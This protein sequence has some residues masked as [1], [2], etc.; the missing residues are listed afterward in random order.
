LDNGTAPGDFDPAG[1]TSVQIAYTITGSSFAGDTWDDLRIATLDDATNTAAFINGTDNSGLGNVGSNTDETDSSPNTGLTQGNWEAMAVSG[2]T[3]IN[4]NYTTWNQDKGKD[5]GVQTMSA[6]VVTITYT[7]GSVIVYDQEHHRIRDDDAPALNANGGGDWAAAEDADW[8]GAVVEQAFRLRFSISVD[9]AVTEGFQLRA[10]KNGAGGYLLVGAESDPWDE[11]AGGSKW[12]VSAIPSAQYADL[13]ATTR[14]L[15]A[16]AGTFR[17]G[18]GNEDPTSG[19]VAFLAA[20]DYTEMEWTVIIRKLARDL[21]DA[22]N[23]HNDDNDFWDFRVYRDDGT[24]LDTYTDTPRV[25][26]TNRVGQIGGA[27]VETPNRIWIKDKS[28]NLYYIGEYADVPTT[29]AVAVMMKSAD[30]G[31]SWNPVGTAPASFDDLESVDM[32]YVEADNEI[33][34][35]AQLNTDA[36]FYSFRVADHASADTWSATDQLVSAATPDAQMANVHWRDDAG[37]VHTNDDTAVCFYH[38]NDGRGRI[39]YRIR[40]S[41]GTWGAEQT[42]DTEASTDFGGCRTVL[43]PADDTIHIFYHA[44]TGTVGS[45]EIWHK[46]LSNADALSG[47]T[48]VDQGGPTINHDGGSRINCIAGAVLWDDGGTVRVG[49][50]YHDD[51]G[52]EDIYWNS[53][54]VSSISFTS[55]EEVALTDV[56]TNV[57]GGAAVSAGVAIDDTDDVVYVM[58][59]DLTATQAYLKYDSRVSGTWQGDSNWSTDRHK[60]PRPLVFTHSAGNGGARVL[61]FVHVD[62]NAFTLNVGAGGTGLI[63]YDEIVIAAAAGS[64]VKQPRPLRAMI[65]R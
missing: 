7:P 3:G 65:G 46:S 33:Y 27:M 2:G 10:Q 40:S 8:A 41:G 19:T 50:A 52:V 38:D 14:I 1:V 15:T 44:F 59:T 16:S 22:A 18:D 5:G 42:V 29:S 51:G 64:L 26:L 37:A 55:G 6:L 45:G 13:D 32:H 48:R 63:R 30:G 43:D 39:R 21:A 24:A 25:T 60:M 12:E 34:I 53:S 31:D 49:A 36:R 61:G 9:G 20:N 11:S 28:G 56:D 58:G 54:A 47:R 23:V 4:Q 35:A 57:L 17:A 62:K